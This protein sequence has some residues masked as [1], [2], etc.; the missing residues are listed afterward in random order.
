MAVAELGVLDASKGLEK[1]DENMM[2]RL[3]YLASCCGGGSVSCSYSGR[4]Y[5]MTVSFDRGNCLSVVL[6]SL[7]DQ[8]EQ[9]VRFEVSL[10]DGDCG[11]YSFGAKKGVSVDDFF[12][13]LW[14]VHVPP[15]VASVEGVPEES[16]LDG[17]AI[18]KLLMFAS[19][20]EGQVVEFDGSKYN[21]SV[22]TG[23][24]NLVFCI[25]L[26]EAG[27]DAADHMAGET[28]LVRHYDLNKGRFLPAGRPDNLGLFNRFVAAMLE[29]GNPAV[30]IIDG[31]AKS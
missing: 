13:L 14:G 2:R 11:A 12:A 18:Y 3:R 23:G 26:L 16:E 19:R 29:Q 28:R 20:A 10:K 15:E 21:V 17:A 25:D 24:Q 30:R 4:S 27:E 22:T 9:S 5:S 8:V 1:C 31:V 6:I 7:G